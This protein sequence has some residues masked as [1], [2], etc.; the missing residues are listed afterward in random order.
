MPF[1]VSIISAM[2]VI[3]LSQSISFGWYRKDFVDFSSH[4][5]S[6]CLFLAGAAL[7][8]ISAFAR[9]TLTKLKALEKDMEQLKAART[10]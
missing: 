10:V 7:L 1:F 6:L 3:I 9:H 5:Q 4:I 2:G 8:F